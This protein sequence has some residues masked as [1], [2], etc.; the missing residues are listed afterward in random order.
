MKW[1]LFVDSRTE[2]QKEFFDVCYERGAR[3]SVAKYYSA[4]QDGHH[5]FQ[6][7][8]QLYC[9]GKNT[10]EYGCGT[11]SYAF[12]LARNGAS[13]TGIDISD[14]AIQKA[15][16]MAIIEEIDIDFRV[17]NCEQLDF[18]DQS[19][20]L[21]CGAGVLHHL[22]LNKAFHEVARTLTPGGK[23]VFIE[24]LGHNP[25]INLYRRATPSLRTTDEH[26]LLMSDMSLACRYFE[27]IETSFFNLFSLL[28]VLFRKQ[29]GLEKIQSI[30]SLLDALTFK[31]VPAAK[32]YAWIVVMEL[33]R[34]RKVSRNA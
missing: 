10:L 32:R 30:L 9:K 1:R 18:D 13:V 3:G 8:I 4:A 11:G 31:L 22:N 15:R 34:P 7:T 24:P 2:Q 23:A 33:S 5:C 26:P 21:I 14:V 28:A 29:R 20:D 16:Q 27:N 12:L 6:R 19:F 25:F 17:G